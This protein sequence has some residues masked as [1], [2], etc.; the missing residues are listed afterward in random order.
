MTS[1]KAPKTIDFLEALPRTGSG[2]I[3]KQALR[4]PYWKDMGKK[5]H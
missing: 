3:Y 4:E 5:V 2:K 1:Y